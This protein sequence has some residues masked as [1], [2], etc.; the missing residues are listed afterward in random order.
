MSRTSQRLSH[1]VEATIVLSPGRRVASLSG[2]GNSEPARN[3]L[4]AI[5]VP[6]TET[7]PEGR[8]NR[9]RS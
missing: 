1:E 8:R 5:R 6:G 3:Y 2:F 7:P 9:K 4:G